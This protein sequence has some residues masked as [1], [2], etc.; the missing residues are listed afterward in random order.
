LFKSG[1]LGFKVLSVITPWG[2]YIRR[3]VIRCHCDWVWQCEALPTTVC[4]S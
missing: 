4:G 3:G 2:P 1:F